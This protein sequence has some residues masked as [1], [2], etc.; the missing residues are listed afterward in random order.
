M[1]QPFKIDSVREVNG[2]NILILE[3][4]EEWVLENLPDEYPNRYL[5]LDEDDIVTG[6]LF[7][8]DRILHSSA[9]EAAEIA[10]EYVK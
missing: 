8:G 7:P 3:Y 1:T 5:W 2:R 6:P 9:A 4:D 10:A